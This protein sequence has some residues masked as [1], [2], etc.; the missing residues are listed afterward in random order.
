[1]G[2]GFFFLGFDFLLLPMLQYNFKDF[3]NEIKEKTMS[4]LRIKGLG[5]FSEIG[6]SGA[7]IEILGN[8]N[9]NLLVDSGI[10]MVNLKENGTFIRRSEGH[11]FPD[12]EIHATLITHGHADHIV[13]LPN[14]LSR[15]PSAKVFWTRPTTH[16]AGKMYESTI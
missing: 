12:K 1:M 9:K 6:A 13:N 5:G 15:Y 8:I 3:Y 7:Q 4:T 16:I 11:S 14:I 10:K 2:V